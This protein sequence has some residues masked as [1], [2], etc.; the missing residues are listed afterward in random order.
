M[1][2]RRVEATLNIRE[3]KCTAKGL[4]TNKNT[5]INMLKKKI[6]LTQVNLVYPYP[7]HQYIHSYTSRGYGCGIYSELIFVESKTLK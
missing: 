1:T 7:E 5:V 3:I 4:K 6:K 2:G